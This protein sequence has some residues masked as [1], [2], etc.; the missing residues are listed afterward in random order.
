MH[1]ALAGA[2]EGRFQIDADVEGDGQ[3]E[4]S[5]G[6]VAFSSYGGWEAEWTIPEKAKLG[7]Y[8]IDCR[9]GAPGSRIVLRHERIELGA[10]E[11]G[12][13]VTILWLVLV[14]HAGPHFTITA[15]LL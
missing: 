4:V 5:G 14:A 1:A 15:R 12:E 7:H 9:V 3:R 8:V 2:D 13:Q 11:A 6:T 10:I